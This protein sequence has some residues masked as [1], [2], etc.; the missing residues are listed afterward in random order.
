VGY[1]DL[2]MRRWNLAPGELGFFLIRGPIAVVHSLK[3]SAA[4]FPV[5]SWKWPSRTPAARAQVH[6]ASPRKGKPG[7]WSGES[8]GVIATATV[9]KT[10][11]RWRPRVSRPSFAV[12][13][14]HLCLPIMQSP[15]K[16]SE[17]IRVSP[18]GRNSTWLHTRGEILCLAVIHPVFDEPS[19]APIHLLET[20]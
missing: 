20:Q 8:D 10:G 5:R 18:A 9:D 15:R 7:T 4:A 12:G 19:L 14:S 1:R 11:S 17:R 3:H 16:Y 13:T 2:P 6:R